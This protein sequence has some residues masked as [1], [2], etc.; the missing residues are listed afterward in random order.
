MS[1]K[2][3]V[4]GVLIVMLVFLLGWGV[5]TVFPIIRAENAT[6]TPAAKVRDVELCNDAL[7]RRRLAQDAIARPASDGSTSRARSD[8]RAAEADIRLY[9]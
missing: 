4:V 2:S 6:P 8:L 9:C 3:V 1:R 7:A 5:G